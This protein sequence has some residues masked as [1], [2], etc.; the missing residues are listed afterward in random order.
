MKLKLEQ[1][2]SKDI[3]LPSGIYICWHK[4]KV[5]GEMICDK[6]IDFPKNCP[7]Q[8]GMPIGKFKDR[9]DPKDVNPYDLKAYKRTKKT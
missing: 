4:S 3:G 5:I 9:P 6:P 1:H 7:L 2:N 8:D